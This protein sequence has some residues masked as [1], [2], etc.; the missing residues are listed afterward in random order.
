MRKEAIRGA[1]V[2]QTISVDGCEN[3]SRVG[4][5][6]ISVV[7]LD[8]EGNISSLLYNLGSTENNDRVSFAL[9][10]GMPLFYGSLM[11]GIGLVRKDRGP[12]LR[13]IA[14]QMLSTFCAN[15]PYQ[16]H[17]GDCYYHQ[18]LQPFTR[19]YPCKDGSDGGDGQIALAWI[20]LILKNATSAMN[21]LN[22]F[23][24]LLSWIERV[25]DPSAHSKHL[26]NFVVKNV[27]LYRHRLG[28]AH[29]PRGVPT[30]FL[31]AT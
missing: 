9:C 7:A 24:E 17:D 27:M 10:V 4:R 14:A 6:L 12:A 15:G 1:R 11:R 31:M 20:R 3:M 30:F 23:V 2:M 18:V 28:I 16:S 19:D 25:D 26:V 8:A 21:E 5:T 13:T 22:C 29:I